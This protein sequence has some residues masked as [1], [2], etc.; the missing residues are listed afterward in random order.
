MGRKPLGEK[1]LTNAEKQKR[2]RKRQDDPERKEKERERKRLA[3]QK[4]NNDPILRAR[5]LQARNKSQ[6][7]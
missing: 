1:C 2:Y 5:N 7:A 6:K 3:R 4:I